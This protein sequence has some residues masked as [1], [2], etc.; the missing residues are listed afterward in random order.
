MGQYKP[1]SGP[2]PVQDK[3]RAGLTLRPN[4]LTPR[5]KSEES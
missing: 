5:D 1:Q 3:Q 4:T 2:G